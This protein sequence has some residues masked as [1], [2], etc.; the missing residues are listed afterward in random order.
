[1]RRRLPATVKMYTGD[2][3]NYPTL[4]AGDEQGFSH[5]LL[6]I[7]DGIAPWLRPLFTRWIK[8]IWTN[9]TRSLRPRFPLTS[10]LP[11]PDLSYK[12]G[13]VFLAW[14]NGHQ[15]EFKM[16]AGRRQPFTEHLVQLF[17]MADQAG[18]F[19]DPELAVARM[20]AYLAT[21]L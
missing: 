15:A 17:M 20:N 3:F 8:G 1:M 16:V 13:I 21:D 6:G 2:D 19:R 14:L 18:L 10:H 12:T 4:I 11:N 5:A 9:T 7:F